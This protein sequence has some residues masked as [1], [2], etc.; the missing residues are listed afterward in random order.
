MNDHISRYVSDEHFAVSLVRAGKTCQ[1]IG[2][3][4]HG[5]VGEPLRVLSQA[6]VC[7][8]LLAT[9]LKGRGLLTISLDTN[10]VFD[11]LRA[12]AIGLGSVRAMIRPETHQQ[13]SDWNGVD[14]LL[15]DGRFTLS[16]QL[17]GTAQPYQSV[18]AVSAAPLRDIINNFVR[19]SE[20]VDAIMFTDIGITDNQVSHAQGI[21]IER[22]P[23]AA[24][25]EAGRHF[26]E[27]VA[28]PEQGLALHALRDDDDLVR[29]LFASDAFRL[30]HRY[31]VGFHCPCS[32][33]RYAATLR[34]FGPDQVKELVNGNGVIE[35]E[36][37]FCRSRYAIPLDEVI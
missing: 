7:S 4:Q 33:E 35:T 37:D 9:R 11:Y 32:A 30:L 23:G 2:S 36:C 18:V 19:D 29:E 15:G 8:L 31:D 24:A 34:S 16:R 13:L 17:E 6:V 22:M 26:D 10:G 1:L 21:Y 25:S 12:D 28:E 20:Q 5:L 3:E 14:P 27:L